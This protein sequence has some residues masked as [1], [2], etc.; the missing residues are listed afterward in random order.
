MLRQQCF[1]GRLARHLLLHIHKLFALKSDTETTLITKLASKQPMIDTF[2][3]G[4]N[5]R[6]LTGS[7]FS[8]ISIYEASKRHY[9][10]TTL[11]YTPL[12]YPEEGKK[13]T[14]TK[15]QTEEHQNRNFFFFKLYKRCAGIHSFD[16]VYEVYS[17]RC[18]VLRNYMQ[19]LMSI[20]N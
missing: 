6:K 16:L 4:N 5:N 15:Q 11:T 12:L 2:G 8:D 17:K 18:S 20:V 9:I 10:F 7:V 14:K 19:K 13:K 1:T 3:I